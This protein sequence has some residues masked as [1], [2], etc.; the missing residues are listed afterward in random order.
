MMIPEHSCYYCTHCEHRKH[1]VYEDH[2]NG[3]VIAHHYVGFFCPISKVGVD[4][5]F[6]EP[7]CVYF[8]RRNETW[9]TEKDTNT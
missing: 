4:D 6:M 2:G 8:E 1:T 5:I 7:D 3:M 9:Q